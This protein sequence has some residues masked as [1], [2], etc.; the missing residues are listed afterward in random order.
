MFFSGYV[1]AL[2]HWLVK[3]FM[4]SECKKK[5]KMNGKILILLIK[6][7]KSSLELQLGFGVSFNIAKQE[8]QTKHCCG[9]MPQDGVSVCINTR[10]L[11]SVVLVLS[12]H[13]LLPVRGWSS[14]AEVSPACVFLIYFYFVIRSGAL[15]R[16]GNR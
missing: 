5:K 6:L 2:Q 1:H 3:S 14:T 12:V 16:V 4:S 15:V 11:P 9:E 10:G 13:T 8:K 7:N